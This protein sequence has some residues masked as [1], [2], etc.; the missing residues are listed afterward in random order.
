MKVG[1]QWRASR[2][3]NAWHH[4]CW[5]VPGC[6]S[7]TENGPG[8]GVPGTEGGGRGGGGYTVACGWTVA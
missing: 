8:A 4:G 7:G 2:A 1:K 5:N 6:G 3:L